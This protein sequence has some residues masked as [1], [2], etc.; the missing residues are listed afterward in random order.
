MLLANKEIEAL[1]HN[2]ECIIKVKTTESSFKDYN[3][4]SIR[5]MSLFLS[6]K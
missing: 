6:K 3:I 1:S 5:E 2:E 4:K